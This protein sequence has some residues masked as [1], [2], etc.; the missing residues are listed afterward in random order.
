MVVTNNEMVASN[1]ANQF[2]FPEA[3]KFAQTICS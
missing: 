2:T 1:T 3:F